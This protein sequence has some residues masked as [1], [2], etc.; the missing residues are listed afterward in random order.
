MLSFWGRIGQI[1]ITIASAVYNILLMRY[2]D[3]D[4]HLIVSAIATAAYLIVVII[5]GLPP[6]ILTILEVG[7]FANSIVSLVFLYKDYLWLAEY[8]N[9]YIIRATFG[10][11][12]TMTFTFLL[13]TISVLYNVTYKM[14]RYPESEYYNE[15]FRCKGRRELEWGA[16]CLIS[17]K[18]DLVEVK[19][20]V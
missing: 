3:A 16:L 2:G 20:L 19:E 10:L 9:T 17:L 12:T 6:L 13:T 4:L 14:I 7:C 5:I 18:S 1:A 11:N 15:F 8:Y